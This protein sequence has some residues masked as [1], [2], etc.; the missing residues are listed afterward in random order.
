MAHL[1]KCDVYYAL[2]GAV[3]GKIQESR[4]RGL[5]LSVAFSLSLS[6][7][8]LA[9]VSLKAVWWWIVESVEVIDHR[10]LI[11][12]VDTLS[13]L[14]LARLR[15]PHASRQAPVVLIRV[16]QIQRKTG[17][18]NT[19][20]AARSQPHAAGSVFMWV[21]PQEILLAN[22]LCI[23]L[24][25]PNSDISYLLATAQ[26]EEEIEEHWQWLLDTLGP[27]LDAFEAPED[28][29]DYV[30]GKAST[31]DPLSKP[32]YTPAANFLTPTQRYRSPLCMP[33][34]HTPLK[35]PICINHLCF[36][37]FIMGEE[38]RLSLPFTE[39]M[40]LRQSTRMLL[41]QGFTIQTRTREYLFFMLNH[42]DVMRLIR[43]L[44]AK[45]MRRLLEISDDAFA[46]TRA[47]FESSLAREEKTEQKIAEPAL[48]DYFARLDL[49]EEYQELFRLPATE[50]LD[51]I[52]Q[53]SVIDPQ[54]KDFVSGRLYLSRHYLCFSSRSRNSCTVILP[55]RNIAS[56]E[57]AER[58]A[59]FVAMRETTNHLMLQEL[60]APDEFI[61]DL[62]QRMHDLRQ[63]RLHKDPATNPAPD[64]TG[65]PVESSQEASARV[66]PTTP[67]ISAPRPDFDTLRAEL[68]TQVLTEPLYLQFG[69]ASGK[70]AKP[71]KK[72][73]STDI[74]E[75]MWDMHFTEH[76]RGISAFRTPADRELIKQGIPQ[77][78]REKIWML[79]S[80]ALND[81]VG[82][83]SEYL[84][85]LATHHGEKTIATEEIERDLH[86]SLP[87][88]P[89]FQ[90]SVG[91]DALRRVLTA[92]SFRTPEIGYCQAMNIVSSVLLIY[93]SE[94]Q[95]Y[96]LLTALC[97][98]LLP[99]YYN[100]KVVGALI[101][102]VL[103][104]VGLEILAQNHAT[105]MGLTE[106][107]YVMAHLS[108]Y[109]QGISNFDTDTTHKGSEK[110]IS[111]SELIQLAYQHYSHVGN[112]EVIE[113]RHRVRLR[114]V[115]TLQD[116]VSKS[117][118]RA[119]VDESLL[120][121]KELF[122]L[123]RVFHEGCM[124]VYY[125]SQD[126]DT[127]QRLLNEEQFVLLIN[128]LTP[129]GIFAEALY[130]LARSEGPIN[131][132]AVA[133]IIGVICHGSI[134]SRL[135][136]L[137]RMHETSATRQQ[138]NV[139]DHEQLA[140]LWRQL[141]L[142]F[143]DMPGE[144]STRY[145]QA[146]NAVVAVA[147]TFATSI[148]VQEKPTLP[149]SEEMP[150]D[151]TTPA[152]VTSPTVSVTE[153]PEDSELDSASRNEPGAATAAAS[154]DPDVTTAT[155]AATACEATHATDAPV[156]DEGNMH[157]SVFEAAEASTA[158]DPT[159]SPASTR[160]RESRRSGTEATSLLTAPVLEGR[161]RTGSLFS[162]S[163]IESQEA[164]ASSETMTFQ[165]FR[166]AVMSQPLITEYFSGDFPLQDADLDQVPVK[167]K[168]RRLRRG[169]S[170]GTGTSTSG[171]GSA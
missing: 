167:P 151:L 102:Q 66:S 134:N 107:C 56:A 114:V 93:C 63:Q 58:Q 158:D 122:I 129:W 89:A 84:D 4:L 128:R 60:S 27:R 26:L 42:D 19:Q 105:L 57:R 33:P 169:A 132:V 166:A 131:F 171:A 70:E 31:K 78:L 156:N 80:G 118:V 116:S 104:M 55:I 47:K 45:A 110:S 64:A 87:E 108:A 46:M 112:E 103:L 97:E 91:I 119:A 34:P 135:I 123:H 120:T 144:E 32:K 117:A 109:L 53:A 67:A 95:A 164:N 15:R 14:G 61:K 154:T 77:G 17:S 163:S 100:T 94:E 29:R 22:A 115:Q 130:Q 165:V 147:V 90:S 73:I 133:A 153:D 127:R 76:G 62:H 141:S 136:M 43:Q 49:N 2:S 24:Q 126:Y 38:V 10:A 8:L 145:E 106:D 101:D 99:D 85:L 12:A 72:A 143:T 3:P 160:P 39:V 139:V 52:H 69:T 96:W 148:E 9:D 121:E 7:K 36:Y 28:L 81:R 150:T 83:E 75:H 25:T 137:L 54:E 138:P 157:D 71:V 23:L 79:Y 124:K 92:Y 74:K 98:R 168:R 6:L 159:D 48:A 50:A 20:P 86:R 41:G 37:S 18:C 88:H 13:E 16:A 35:M 51:S 152:S 170:K 59:V 21:A 125:W 162:R 44:T 68:A 155:D 5:S 111:V 11:A 113:M 140:L 65:R 1:L 142:L 161:P 82:H 149:S 146:F 40:A 30:C